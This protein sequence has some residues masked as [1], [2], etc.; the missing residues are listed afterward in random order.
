MQ[1]SRQVSL[2]RGHFNS[3]GVTRALC[4]TTVNRVSVHS[5]SNS[6]GVVCIPQRIPW[7]L[8]LP[9][10]DESPLLSHA[11]H[12]WAWP[13]NSSPPMLEPSHGCPV[14]RLKHQCLQ[15][16]TQWVS[17]ACDRRRS[18]S[19]GVTATLVRTP[20]EPGESRTVSL[21]TKLIITRRW[22]FDLPC[23]P[24]TLHR[25]QG[26]ASTPKTGRGGARQG[27]VRWEAGTVYVFSTSFRYP[28]RSLAIL[29]AI[30][31]RQY[32]CPAFRSK[33]LWW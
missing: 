17:I 25:R 21:P 28:A 9:G 23:I 27:E 20:C 11:H 32:A 5:F 30:T 26:L 7:S 10:Q 13:S 24:D 31:T 22:G 19:P 2:V 4:L 15:Q 16:I 6:T 3:Y 33:Y 1:W 12:T 14:V 18:L 29:G 8:L